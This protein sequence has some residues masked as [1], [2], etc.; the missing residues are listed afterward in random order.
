MYVNWEG[1]VCNLAWGRWYCCR[2]LW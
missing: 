2:Y 1:I